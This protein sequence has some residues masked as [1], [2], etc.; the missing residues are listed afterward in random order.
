MFWQVYLNLENEV[1]DLSKYI[2]FTDTTLKIDNKTKTLKVVD[3]NYHLDVY[4]PFIADLLVRCC[5]EIE[6]ISKELYFDN[7]GTKTRGSKDIYFDTD[8]IA[9][10]NQNWNIEDKTVII[11]TSNFHFTKEENRILT[12]LKGADKRSKVYWAKSY[13]A[14][15]HDRYNSLYLGNIKALLQSIAALYLLNIYYK[16]IKFSTKYLEYRK[17]D[18][19]FGS[20]IFTIKLPNDGYIVDVINGKSI[21]DVLH[22]EDSP[23]I[24]KYVDSTY[25]EVIEA[26]KKSVQ[27]VNDYWIA[28]SELKEPKFIKQLEYSRKRANEDPKH[29]VI[30]L[31]ELCQ[32]RLNKKIPS[33]LSFEE[34][35][36]LFVQSNEWSVLIRRAN[37]PKKES[38]L[39]EE[40]LQ[41][42]IDRA[43]ISAGIEL[44]Q[45]F[46]NARFVKSFNEGYCELVLDKGNVRY[47][48]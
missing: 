48:L 42:E 31:W 30:P 40:N 16:D 28:Q 33:L 29:R 3:N 12:P 23:Y 32:Y 24:L 44:S 13:Q 47:N 34:R 19:S 14:V 21:T 26:N 38:E 11:S 8:C 35:K 45:R 17:L 41:E 39:T 15:K 20:K 18:M 2:L 27:Q 7:G 37:N 5:V 10:L 4:S 46:E 25:R 6:A 36:K 43:G 1:L 9:L 22:S